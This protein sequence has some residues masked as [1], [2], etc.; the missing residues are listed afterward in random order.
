MERA[1]QLLPDLHETLTQK[2]GTPL[3][4]A[5]MYEDVKNLVVHGV[6][7]G[8]NENDFRIPEP[9]SS[10]TLKLLAKNALLRMAPE[11]Y[12]LKLNKRISEMPAAESISTEAAANLLIALTGQERPESTDKA[13]DWLFAW[14]QEGGGYKV[15]AVLRDHWKESGPATSG[16]LYYLVNRICLKLAAL[17]K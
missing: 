14:M 11:R 1:G 16:E 13:S 5:W 9:C 15:P 2:D 6:L 12:T 10:G 3:S 4:S 8:G 17:P 7:L